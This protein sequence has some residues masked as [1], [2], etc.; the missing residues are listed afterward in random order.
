MVAIPGGKFIMGSPE[1]EHNRFEDESPQYQVTV[2][3]FFMGKY[4]VIQTQWQAM[5]NTL[6]VERE[7][8]LNSCGFEE[9][10]LPITGVY[11][12]EAIEFCHRLS[13]DTGRNYRLP[14]ETEWEY[15]YRAGTQ[16]PLIARARILILIG[17][18]VLGLGGTMALSGCTRGANLNVSNRSTAELTNVVAAGAGFTQSIGSNEAPQIDTIRL[19]ADLGALDSALVF[20]YLCDLAGE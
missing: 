4:P 10:D 20:T 1:S 12:D 5:A 9:D 7:L 17:V 15:A 16:T 11:W 2:Q 14:T 18:S 8:D 13:R 3:P 19:V 6:P